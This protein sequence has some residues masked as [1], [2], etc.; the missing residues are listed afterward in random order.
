MITI[1]IALR[2]IFRYR[3]RSIITLSAI[4]F[5]CA[6]LIFAGGYFED[7]FL[8]MRE[9]YIHGHTG[10]LQVFKKGFFEQGSA[11]PFEYLIDHPQKISGLISNVKGV[12][13]VTERLDFAAL[14]S[15]GE[16]TVSFIGRGV[17]PDNETAV[18]ASQARTVSQ[19][20]KTLMTSGTL[21]KTGQPLKNND[22]FGVISGI[23]LAAGIGVKPGDGLIIIANTVGG[24][25]N[26]MDVTLKGTFLTGSKEFD[27]HFIELPVTT[28]QKLLH[29]ESVQLL[30]VM[31]EK[32]EDT[33]RVKKELETIFSKNNPDLEIKTWDQLNDFYAK[34]VTLF[35]SLFFVLK[36]VITIIVILSIF[37]TMN[38][39]VLE[40][41]NEIG[42][43]MAMGTRR[44]GVVKLFLYEG[45]GL[46]LIGGALGILTGM[47][48]TC[49][50]SYI[51]IPMPPAPNMT[52]HWVSEPKIVPAILIFA[53]LLSLVTALLSSL[54]PAYKASR[55]EIADALRHT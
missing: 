4:A 53:F 52:F 42:T 39:A 10:H 11:R 2:N 47:I 36:I 12:K 40:R 33:Q 22:P 9:S 44:N 19:S 3:V 18:T 29:T 28:V 55:L 8:K 46:G 13:F 49:L 54:Y 27:D 51:G 23:G 41:T 30:T 48:L 5:G 37:N 38:M 17:N 25:I 21:M 16:N 43:L 45:L 26:A 34:T 6:A 7:I 50:I 1:K 32:T 20:M 24:S 14:I 35:N 31:L 15:T